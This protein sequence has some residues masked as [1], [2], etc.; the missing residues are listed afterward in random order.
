MVKD[1]DT[2]ISQLKL[3]LQEK[4]GKID[5]KQA[6]LGKYLSICILLYIALIFTQ[7]NSKVHQ[8]NSERKVHT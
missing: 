5:A 2:E 6:E 8:T 7:T 1:K 3:D 4:Q